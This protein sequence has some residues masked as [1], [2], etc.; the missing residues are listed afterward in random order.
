MHKCSAFAIRVKGYIQ[1]DLYDPDLVDDIVAQGLSIKNLTALPKSYQCVHGTGHELIPYQDSLRPD[2]GSVQGEAATDEMLCSTWGI[3]IVVNRFIIALK[4]LASNA[5]NMEH[6]TL[7]YAYSLMDLNAQRRQEAQESGT[8]VI[9][10]NL[11]HHA[12]FTARLAIDTKDLWEQALAGDLD[13]YDICRDV[14]GAE[15]F[16]TW[17]RASA[18]KA[19]TRGAVVL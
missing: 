12:E 16:E 18:S 6:E 15:V 13:A 1:G 7:T 17:T 4:P 5:R 19:P 14:I 11:C 3:H 8:K 9:L 10:E 2:A